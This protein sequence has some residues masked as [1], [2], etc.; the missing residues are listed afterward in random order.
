MQILQVPELGDE[1]DSVSGNCDNNFENSQT[2]GGAKSCAVADANS[3]DDPRLSEILARW[4][5]LPERVREELY[6]L[7][8]NNAVRGY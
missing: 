5:A 4:S 6:R 7:G 2:Q 3:A 8:W 1:L